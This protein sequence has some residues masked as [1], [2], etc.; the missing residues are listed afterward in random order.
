MTL[1]HDRL[2]TVERKQDSLTERVVQCEG[3]VDA[4][5][6]N[7]ASQVYVQ[8]KIGNIER[9]L[10]RTES[11]I[12]NTNANIVALG[13]RMDETTSQTAGQ[14]TTLFSLHNDVLKKSAE[15]DERLKQEY[16]E[17]QQKLFEAKLEQERA[18]AAERLATAEAKR[19]TAEQEAESRKLTNRLKDWKVVLGFII[20]LATVLYGLGELFRYLAQHANVGQK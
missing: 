6:K 11:A 10:E 9:T 8:E 17:Q 20:A 3:K 14:L 2:T 15:Y 12:A 18:L 16:I 13:K 1:E 7:Y 5:A 4:L 19:K